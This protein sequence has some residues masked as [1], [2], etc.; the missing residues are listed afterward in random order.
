MVGKSVMKINARDY[1]RELERYKADLVKKKASG[2][3]SATALLIE[4]DA[5]TQMEREFKKSASSVVLRWGSDL[6]GPGRWYENWHVFF[7]KKH[8]PELYNKRK[9]QRKFEEYLD[10]AEF[11]IR[12][13][14]LWRRHIIN[15]KNNTHWVDKFSPQLQAI[16]ELT[17]SELTNWAK[18]NQYRKDYLTWK[19]EDGLQRM[20]IERP[21]LVIAIRIAQ[22]YGIDSRKYPIQVEERPWYVEVIEIGVSL[23]PIAGNLV[24]AY[25]VEAGH[26]LFGYALDP[27]ERAIIAG[28]ILFPFAARFVKGGRALYT[29]Q[30]MV[31]LYGKDAEVWSRMMA[32]GERLSSNPEMFRL[33]HQADEV[34]RGRK[35]LGN[36]L[37]KEVD[38]AMTEVRL[39][40]KATVST[41][42][43]SRTVKEAFIKLS[44][45]HK[46]IE[47][48]D[49]L[50]IQRI[51]QNGPN[52]NHMKGQLL[53]ELLET[54]VVKFL[55]DPHAAK[56]LGINAPTH[57]LR[58]I[59]GHL[60][61][62]T[63]GR[64]ISDG[65]LVR[66]IKDGLE[67][68]GIFEAKAGKRS[69][70]ELKASS[71]SIKYLSKDDRTE[72]RAYAKDVYRELVERARLDGS[73]VTKNIDQIE[74]EIIKT[75][76]GGQVR[77]DIERLDRNFGGNAINIYIGSVETQIRVSATRTRIFGVL[78]K[79]LKPGNL[80]A[81]LQELGYNFDI[82][83]IDITTKQLVEI[84]K[85]L[86]SLVP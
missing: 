44:G 14:H 48:L 36:K 15:Y 25:E 66:K 49:E 59:P 55:E 70:R 37:T 80:A 78:P 23:V 30:R 21:D 8:D 85:K 58:F 84:A 63:A 50:A 31:K 76:H 53:E 47:E 18:T 9:Y 83:G 52:V 4:S 29:S 28:S 41:P 32:S 16:I 10:Y 6:W 24:A 51:I 57:E 74:K 27:T 81:D 34:V 71:T 56:A 5:L 19:P 3:A 68:L 73:K 86:S 33:L 75:E 17:M 43:V 46:I 35:A 1:W 65:I 38:E 13:S 7:N 54:R 72:L 77:R 2:T 82:F 45:K 26:D 11:N 61:R 60:V 69:A 62:D 67:I 79:D 40:K 64:Q 42:G 39:G 20:L 22:I 12:R